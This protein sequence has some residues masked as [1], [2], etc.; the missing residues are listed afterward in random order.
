MEGEIS[1]IDSPMDP[2]ADIPVRKLL[3]MHYEEGSTQSNG[4]VLRSVPGDWV[5]PFLH[6]R[7]GDTGEGIE[8]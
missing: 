3:S 4:T 8:I 1:L 6:Q 2:V 7:Y 5:L